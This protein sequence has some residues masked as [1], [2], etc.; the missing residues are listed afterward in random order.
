MS[1]T[2]LITLNFSD[3]TNTIYS[4]SA[5]I[6]IPFLCSS[7]VV[8][9]ETVYNTTPSAFT[10]SISC[11]QLIEQGST[12]L[13]QA[14]A[15]T[16][17]NPITHIYNQPKHINGNYNFELNL[18]NTLAPTSVLTGDITLGTTFTNTSVNIPIIGQ[19]IIGVNIIQPCFII[20]SQGGN[21]YT[22]ST[23][24]VDQV[25]SSF[26]GYVP[27]RY[28]GYNFTFF[29][30]TMEIEFHENF[31]LFR[32]LGI[33]NASY[34]TWRFSDT[35]SP[36]QFIDIPF[37]VH[38]IQIV[39]VDVLSATFRIKALFSDLIY[40]SNGI[41]DFQNN[42]LINPIFTYQ[43]NSVQYQANRLLWQRAWS[44]HLSN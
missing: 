39:Q 37:P 10:A 42:N 16:N 44:E 9:N 36:S 34:F 23:P 32:H 29:Y 33:Q 26:T 14:R 2:R 15:F 21:V 4:K 40:S 18:G 38:E 17:G 13:T 41:Q 11:S 7:I 27:Y 24:Q 5:N 35:V 19:A 1:A 6:Y 31:R 12:V 3:G 43:V 20:S 22:L 30:L 8:K 28:L 25:N